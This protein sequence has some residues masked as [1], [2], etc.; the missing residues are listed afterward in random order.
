[1]HKQQTSKSSNRQKA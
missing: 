1:M